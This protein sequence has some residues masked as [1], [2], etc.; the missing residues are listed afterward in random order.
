M[1][2]KASILTSS[3]PT[4]QNIKYLYYKVTKTNVQHQMDLLYVP[5]NVYKG[6]T[7]KYIL[8]DVDVASRDKVTRTL[9]TKKATEDAFV[10]EAIYKSSCTFKYPKVM[11]LLMDLSFF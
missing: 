1:V 3:Y 5:H 6:S 9:R 7:Y 2:S 8:T 4:L 11:D 10:L